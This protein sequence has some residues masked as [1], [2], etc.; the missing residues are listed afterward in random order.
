M[1]YRINENCISCGACS[2]VC[3]ENAIDD[4]YVYHTEGSINSTT[5]VV[6]DGAMAGK[7]KLSQIWQGYRITSD[8]SNCG[9]CID[10]CPVG[11]IV[12]E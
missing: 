4:G 5:D 8:C 6:M 1:A 2:V 12:F 10:V 3:P 9:K 7:Q 11:A